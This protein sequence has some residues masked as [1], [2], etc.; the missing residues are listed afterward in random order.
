[1]PSVI[2]VYFSRPKRDAIGT[3][4]LHASH[5]EFPRRF[6]TLMFWYEDQVKEVEAR[7]ES[8]RANTDSF[9]FYGSSSFNYWKGKLDEDMGL[10]CVNLAFGGSTLAACCWFFKRLVGE[11]KSRGLVLYAGDNDIGDG[12]HSEEVANHFRLLAMDWAELRPNQPLVVLSVKPSPAR[13]YLMETIRFANVHIS[14][15]CKELEFCHFVDV[16]SDM[17]DEQGRPNWRFFEQDGL[18]MNRGGYELW[19]T[20]L[21]PVL[22]ELQV[23]TAI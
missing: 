13:E 20:K 10:P 8:F 6:P 12:R 22:E 3:G 15:I 16:F 7:L 18:H 17:L 11:T 21:R 4:T 5:E 1:M 9:V 14:N 19:I 2:L 23:P